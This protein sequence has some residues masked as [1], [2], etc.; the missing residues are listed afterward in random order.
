MLLLFRRRSDDDGVGRRNCSLPHENDNTIVKFV[1]RRH[2]CIIRRIGVCWREG[3]NA[4]GIFF[5]FMCWRHT[6]LCVYLV[7]LSVNVAIIC[8]SSWMIICNS[9]GGY[10]EEL[11]YRRGAVVASYGTLLAPTHR[12]GRCVNV[13]GVWARDALAFTWA[14]E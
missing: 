4:E 3:N 11:R 1:S 14:R 10:E 6:S 5:D 12:H 7:F 9:E 8:D 13:L 2:N